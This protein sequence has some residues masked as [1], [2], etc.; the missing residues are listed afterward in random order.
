MSV[1]IQDLQ[2]YDPAAAGRS[3][4]TTRRQ[5][6]TTCDDARDVRTVSVPYRSLPSAH[7]EHRAT[8]D[9]SQ[10][11]RHRYRYKHSRRRLSAR[12]PGRI[13]SDVIVATASPLAI[14]MFDRS[15]SIR[16]TYSSSRSQQAIVSLHCES[17]CTN[18]SYEN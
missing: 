1:L 13:V 5:F 9:L 10:R 15:Y 7:S 8:Q 16:I 11:R 18:D 12:F 14:D 4:V 17:S 3:R 2:R 6:A